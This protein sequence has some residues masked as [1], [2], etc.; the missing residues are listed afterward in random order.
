MGAPEETATLGGAMV[1][2][3]ITGATSAGSVRTESGIG[4]GDCLGRYTIRERL[5]A[6]GMGE[7]FA[8]HD[9]ELD[10]VVAIK[11]I[12]PEVSGA[13]PQARA[14]FQR[15]AQAMARLNH[16]NVVA[17]HDA[18][19]I[20]DRVFVAM[21][22]V[23]G[24]T[25]AAW[26][27]GGPR[28]WR[29]V[30]DV[31][32]QAG[33]GLAAAHAAGMVHRDFK[34]SNVIIGDRVRVADFGLARAAHEVEEAPGEAAT[35]LEGVVTR[36][37]AAVGTPAYMAP[38]QR[39]GGAVSALSDQYAFGV[40][41]HEALTGERPGA[42]PPAPG[43]RRPWPRRLRA[44][45]AR[46]RAERPEDRYPS[47]GELLADLGRDP[48]AARRPWLALGALGVLAA[49]GLVARH[50]LATPPC[51]GAAARLAGVWDPSRR[52]QVHAA[53]VAA[54][55]PYAEEAWRGT[56]KRL[57]AYADRW[58]AMQ[59]EACRAT[60]V[61]GRQSAALLDL[62]TDC[63]D[64]R[65]ALFGSLTALW[66][67]G[68]DAREVAGAVDAAAGLPTLAV[69]ADA[70]ALTERAP[71]PDD[72]AAVTRIGAARVRIDAVGALIL[73]GR[74]DQARTAAVA[75]RAA[76]DATGWAQVRAEAAYA[77]GDALYSLQD[78][79]AEAV[80]LDA[81]RLAGAARDDHAAGL[82]LVKLVAH[83][84]EQPD[85]AARALVVADVAD[86]LVARNGDDDQRDMLLRGRAQAYLTLGRRDDARRAFTEA[87][88]HYLTRYGPGDR[89][90]LA[91]L[92]RLGVVAEES[93][94]YAQ[95][96][97]SY[98]QE[99]A[100]L[101]ALL[102]ENHIAVASVL[103]NLAIAVDRGTGDHERA[104]GYLQRAVAIKERVV[105]DS[106][107]LAAS[108]ANLAIAEARRGHTDAAAPLF[109]RALAIEEKLYGAGSLN[110]ASAL[111][112]LAAVRRMQGRRAEALE[113]SRRAIAI[114]SKELGPDDA[115]TASPSVAVGEL[116]EAEG[117]AAAALESYRHALAVRTATLG[118]DHQRTLTSMTDVGRALGLLHRCGEARPLLD[119][120]AAGMEKGV[121]VDHPDYARNLAD[122]ARCDLQ[123]GRAA[124][125]VTRLQRA[126]AIDERAGEAVVVRGSIRWLLARGLWAAGRHRDA[127][128]AAR[129]AEQELGAGA[130]GE[131]DRADARAWLDAHGG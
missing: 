29:E 23:E 112:N 110:T 9:P 28:S 77:L 98:Q 69:C 19:M 90:T 3:T 52:E 74:Y 87:H 47:M 11:V 128:S 53:F 60:R 31:F 79:G 61:D 7:V 24:P 22:L 41:L 81:A 120:A 107:G 91:T 85:S 5:G 92:G 39:T 104:I 100:G 117:D 36:T 59:T 62:R 97:R 83:L 26:L 113:L 71:P 130:D 103:N 18:G 17:V 32:L 73:A 118:A 124:Q 89:E 126:L 35:L 127:V 1:A 68:M 65:R 25:L 82:A 116:Q 123:Q 84:A 66:A 125:A 27:A 15:E 51:T 99:L 57:D 76:A 16:P 56:R 14:R 13:S 34:P 102:G 54:G 109:E 114:V 45:V 105:P 131:R 95:A 93:G 63:L 88:D 49:G 115:R 70:R 20:G 129:Q 10:R 48:A 108:L 12:R 38:E 37:G 121:G 106:E 55:T 111:N 122:L 101:T 46:A 119:A 94:D 78:P 42:P 30:V 58:V 72:A 43:S 44:V 80:L 33:R 4:P 67:K 86:G 96:V 8:A 75:A 40:S 21:E 6:G 50:E 2:S 64:R